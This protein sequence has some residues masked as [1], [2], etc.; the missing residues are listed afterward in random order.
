MHR[1]ARSSR[2]RGPSHGVHVFFADDREHGNA[3]TAHLLEYFFRYRANTITPT[4]E[5]ADAC[6]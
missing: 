1:R 4:M 2:S 6:E 5:V 3:L